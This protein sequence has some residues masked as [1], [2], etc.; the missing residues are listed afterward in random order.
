[1]NKLT[2]TLSVLGLFILYGAII[3]GMGWRSGGGLLP[4]LIFIFAARVIWIGIT[5]AGSSK[6]GGIDINGPPS[7]PA[8]QPFSGFQDI[9]KESPRPAPTKLLDSGRD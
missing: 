4:S 6:P 2:G 8:P 7:H 1:M 3:E 5:R 9:P